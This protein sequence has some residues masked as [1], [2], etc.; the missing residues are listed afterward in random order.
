MIF[1]YNGDMGTFIIVLI[2]DEIFLFN[3]S[4]GIFFCNGDMERLI[5]LSNSPYALLFMIVPDFM[6]I[7]FNGYDRENQHMRKLEI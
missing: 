4:C 7:F 5:I 2:P 6:S 1:F 3:F